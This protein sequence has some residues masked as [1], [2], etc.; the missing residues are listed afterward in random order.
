MPHDIS[1]TRPGPRRVRARGRV[2]LLMS[3]D[4][5][6]T[7]PAAGASFACPA[8][9]RCVA[10]RLDLTGADAVIA[11]LA[12]R[13]HGV[14]SW[15]QLIDAGLG[16]GAIAHRVRG[17]LLHRLYR[18]VFAVGYRPSTRHARWMA[19]VLAYGDR[20][21]LSHTSAL[22]HWDLRQSSSTMIDITVAT[23]NGLSGRAGIRLHRCGAL[24]EADVTERHRIRVTTVARTLLDAAASLQS[25]SLA[26]TIERSEILEL[27]D[28][29]AVERTLESHVNHPGAAALAAA[30]AL[31]RDD[32]LTRSD[33]EAMLLALCDAHDLP[34]PLVNHVVDGDEV[35]FLWPE[36]RLIVEVDGRRTHLT[37]Q[38]FERDRAKDARLTVAG[39][40]V[41]RFTYRQVSHDPQAVA[42]T[43]RALLRVA[44]AA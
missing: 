28:L 21:A 11:G 33:L 26:R 7:R 24:T 14:A 41:V 39:Y 9:C 25:P 30:I 19:A 38:A 1:S 43:L 27:F 36:Q 3:D 44:P 10:R 22:A 40:R 4:D 34:R 31:Y 37:P 18:G 17:G 32:E 16:P 29:G 35:D 42:R 2:E 20:A 12:A 23:R 13:Q 6:S 15:R 8:T 5:N